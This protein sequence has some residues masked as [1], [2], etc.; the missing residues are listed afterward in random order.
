MKN[1]HKKKFIK[2]TLL[3]LSSLIIISSIGYTQETWTP[4]G[5]AEEK[6]ETLKKTVEKILM[7]I[8]TLKKQQSEE[9]NKATKQEKTISDL[10]RKIDGIQNPKADKKGNPFN[11]F[12]F[13]GYGELHANIN[14]D[15]DKDLFDLHRIVFYAGYD[16]SDWIKLNS[17]IEIEHGF[18]SDDSGGELV[19]EQ[20]FVDFSINDAINIR[21]GRILT[22]LGI[23]NQKHEP[24]SFNGVERPS[25][26]KYIIPSTWSSDGIGIFGRLCPSISYE[27][28][29]VG[30][31]DGS[32]FT[33]KD[34][35][36]KGRIKERPGLH[37]P[38]VTARLDIYPFSDVLLKNNQLFRMGYSTYIGG[39]DN[40][41]N[42]KN[43]G[44]DGDIRIYA[45]DFDYTIMELMDL[46]GEIAF[47]K[48]S[49][50]KSIGSQTAE[51]I[52][53]WYL[54][55]GW[56]FW[57]ESFKQKKLEKSD[58]V[59]FVRYDDYDTQYDMPPGVAGVPEGDRTDWTF[60][61]NFYPVQNFVA[62][63]D[64]QIRKD[65]TD[66]DESLLNLGLG[67]QF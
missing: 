12:H 33:A 58:A 40:G 48:I 43:P 36:R 57:P 15:S 67:W 62:K 49:G 37:E 27:A 18:V 29:V 5:S 6:I 3:V 66:A 19:I 26:A 25:F 63:L 50:A 44:I 30:G 9:Q 22:P 16:F 7:E 38:A 42:G 52:F 65:G 61:I 39:L 34:G 31:L 13:G 59:F 21:A 54:E 32:G 4:E 14:M 1:C 10:S 35:I 51:N 46:R 56:H 17:E 41:N 8:E 47:E 28:Y 23:I 60:G 45:A 2:T 20:A 11:R 24:T 53:G 55:A 64:Y